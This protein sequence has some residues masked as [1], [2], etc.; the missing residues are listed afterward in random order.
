MRLGLKLATLVAAITAFGAYASAARVNVGDPAPPLTVGK[1]VKGQPV[2]EFEKG[3]VY[4]VEF[5]ATWCGPCK[6]AIPHLTELAKSNPDVTFI[7]ANVL[8]ENDSAVEPFVKEIGD[9][10]DYR[11]ATD[12]KSTI[13][14]GAMLDGWMKAAGQNGIPATFIINKEGK[15]AWIGLPTQMDPVLAS[16]VAGT[17]DLAEATRVAAEAMAKMEAIE[18][19]KAAVRDQMKAPLSKK[20]FDAALAVIDG[21]VAANPDARSALLHMK[22][23]IAMRGEKY[24]LAYQVADELAETNKEDPDELNQLAW[25][26]ADNK[27]V[28]TRDLD[29]ALR[30]AQWAVEA[31]DAKS[32]EILDTLARVQF[33][34]GDVDQAIETQKKAVDLSQAGSKEELQKTLEKYLAARK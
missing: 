26:I 1:W 31:S 22:F 21:A 23:S 12:D 28:K 3:K 30:Y 18:A 29:R 9:K 5:W 20:D 17:Y 15:I 33:D 27:S 16:V 14:D 13:E 34:K 7:G 10:M 11:V 32:G 2:T 24:P 6:R 19:V 25:F 4:V 8:E